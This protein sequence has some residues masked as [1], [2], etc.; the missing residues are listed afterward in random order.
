LLAWQDRLTTTEGAAM[1]DTI[2]T[3]RGEHSAWYPAERAT[4]RAGVNADGPKREEVL[5]SAVAASDAVRGL[6]EPL[7]DPA[8]G[9]VTWW[10]SASVRVWSERPWNNEGKQ[11]PLVYHSAVDFTAK[12]ND[13]D[14]LARWVEET[15]A[16]EG[17]VIGSIEWDLTDATRKSVTDDARTRAVQ[18]AVAKA[19]VYA[20]AIGLGPVT[21]T[22]VADP[23]MLGDGSGGGI[24]PAPVFARADLKMQSFAG[25]GGAPELALKPEE[26]AVASAVDARFVA[27]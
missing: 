12:F 1:A 24:G 14:A 3:V 26:I 20:Q 2:I 4:V 27:R 21:V 9:P 15:A 8:S 10:S 17:A 13:F 11:L 7:F 22:A 25:G 6:I 16:I 18:D 19:T 23:G 5:A